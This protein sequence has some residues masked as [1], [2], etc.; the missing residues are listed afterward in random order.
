MRELRVP[1]ASRKDIEALEGVIAVEAHMYHPGK[2]TEHYR[3]LKIDAHELEKKVKILNYF[4]AAEDQRNLEALIIE[5]ENKWKL[6]LIRDKR[7]NNEY[8]NSL[9]EVIRDDK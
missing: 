4:F 8:F 7:K 1:L 6:L 5:I 3:Y 9:E 2:D